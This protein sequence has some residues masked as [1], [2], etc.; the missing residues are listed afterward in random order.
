MNKKLL[1]LYVLA[2]CSLIG[3]S[4]AGQKQGEAFYMLDA[5]HKGTSPEKAIYFIHA[6]KIYDSC[7]QFDEYSLYGPIISSGQYKD[8]KGEVA[9]GHFSFYNSKGK[10]DSSGNYANG[11]QDGDWYF[12]NDTSRY[13]LQ[14]KYASGVLADQI[15]IISQD[16]IN[17]ERLDN[18]PENSTDE[19]EA[20]FIGGQSRWIYYLGKNMVYPDR[21]LKAD[22]QGTVVVQFVI[23]EGGNV[24]NPEIAQSVEYSIDREALRIIK[25]SPTWKPGVRKGE[26]IKAF[27]KQ[28]LTFRF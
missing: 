26:H 11:L 9:N 19:V 23:D 24:I 7:W 21:A 28:P 18:A 6:E 13:Y 25:N 1:L 5:N 15:D 22:I 17:K 2:C 8:E 20:D 10:I 12:F 27:K 16:A 4:Q 3:F 14:K